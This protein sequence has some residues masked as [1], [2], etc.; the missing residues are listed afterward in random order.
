MCKKIKILNWDSGKLMSKR[1]N[2]CSKKE[3][4]ESRVKLNKAS[5][6]LNSKDCGN[7]DSWDD[8]Q[9]IYIHLQSGKV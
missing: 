8:V 2:Y 1:K 4:K 5:K 3:K 9:Y 6:V 7:S